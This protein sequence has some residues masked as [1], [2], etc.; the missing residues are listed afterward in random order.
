[1]YNKLS[2]ETT[3]AFSRL[4]EV[5]EAGPRKF[6]MLSF[7]YDEGLICV[8]GIGQP[9]TINKFECCVH[10]ENGISK[11][12]ESEQIVSHTRQKI[13]IYVLFFG[14]RNTI[15]QWNGLKTGHQNF[16]LTV[17]VPLVVAFAGFF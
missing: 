14:E 3:V 6:G 9:K 5:P 15:Y 8:G 4:A 1:M 11:D 16:C 2:R 12:T 10:T 7:Q 17:H 13:N